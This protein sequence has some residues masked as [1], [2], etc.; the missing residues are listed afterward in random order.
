MP[1]QAAQNLATRQEEETLV[2]QET[3]SVAVAVEPPHEPEARQLGDLAVR[4]LLGEPI[5]LE[6]P[7]QTPWSAGEA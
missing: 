4:T 7:P 3:A 2:A 5:L 6:E 1:G